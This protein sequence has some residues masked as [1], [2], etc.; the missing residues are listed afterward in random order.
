MTVLPRLNR[1]LAVRWLALAAILAAACHGSPQ[2]D[3]VISLNV[4]LKTRGSPALIAAGYGIENLPDKWVQISFYEVTKEKNPIELH[5]MT[6]R[7]GTCLMFS[8]DKEWKRYIHWHFTS[9]KDLE[10][11]T[12]STMFGTL[13]DSGTPIE[14][15]TID[16]AGGAKLSFKGNVN[17]CYFEVGTKEHLI[18]QVSH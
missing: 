2:P 17:I 7:S 14:V 8:E 18:R 16:N 1:W 9:M 5:V 4:L 11:F 12:G 3:L 10:H 15:Y 6:V 13:T